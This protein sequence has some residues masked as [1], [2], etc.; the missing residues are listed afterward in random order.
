MIKLKTIYAL[1][2]LII[3]STISCSKEEGPGGT[4]DIVGRVWV[5]NYNQDFSI[6]NAEYWAEEENVYLMY[7]SDTIYSDRTKTNFDGSYWFQNLREGDYKVYVYSK[8]STRQSPSQRVPVF[9]TV[10][11][12][13]KGKTYDVPTITILN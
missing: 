7:G 3:F 4:S 2:V 8:D 13:D 12:S 1:I 5:R 9:E 10:Q 11:I 6:L